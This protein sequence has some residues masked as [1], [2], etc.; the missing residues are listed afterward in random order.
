MKVDGRLR[1]L[2][3]WWEFAALYEQLS[4]RHCDAA[5]PKD[6]TTKHSAQ[7]TD[8]SALPLQDNSTSLQNT[9]TITPANPT[10][11][12]S[13]NTATSTVENPLK[14]QPEEKIDNQ[15]KSGRQGNGNRQNQTKRQREWVYLSHYIAINGLNPLHIIS[16][17]DDGREPDF[18]LVF[19]QQSRLYY[20]GVELTTLPRLRD[21]MGEAA[22][23]AK[24]WYWQGLRVMAMR[25]QKQASYQRFRLPVTTLY[26]PI[27]DF[28]KRL[29]R[30]PR[31]IITQQD[32]DAVMAKKAHKA[33]AY[34]TRRPLD[35]LWLLVHCDKYQPESILTASKASITLTHNSD[36]DQVQITRY[37]SHKVIDVSRSTLPAAP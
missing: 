11:L 15:S 21:Q 36:F 8:D 24:R 26:M 18:T 34:H 31:S 6:W 10:N 2:R 20:V 17:Q 29:Y 25:R 33:A 27:D 30:L 13:T 19:Y 9:A 5:S 16:G 23:I 14:K 4:Q 22:L 12:S 1:K 3:R 37:P 32:V 35:E 7:L 28:N